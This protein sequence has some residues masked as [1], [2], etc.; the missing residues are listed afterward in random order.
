MLAEKICGMKD[1]LVAAIRESLRVPSVGG[2][3]AEGAPYGEGPRKALDWTLDFAAR[4]GFR[5]KNVDNVAG[6]AEM[7]TGDEMVA[8][9]GHLDVVPEGKGWTVDPWGGELKDGMIWGRGVLDNKGPVMVALFAAKALFDAGLKLKRRVRVIFG[10]NEERGS[11]CMKRY[12]ELG[13]ELPA[14]GFTPDADYPIIYAEKGIITYTLSMPFAPSGD[15]KVVSLEGG[16]AANVVMAEVK[17]VIEDPRPE[18]RGRILTA[19]KAWKGPQ[20][21]SLEASE[22]GD[23]VT[24]LMKG[25]PAHGSTPEKGVNAL[26]CLAGFMR[27]ARLKGEQ[28]EFFNAFNSTVAFETDG[29]S[30]AVAMKDSVSGSLTACVGVVKAA[31]GRVSFTVNLRYPVTAAEEDVTAPIE[32]TFKAAGMKVESASKTRPLYMPP[33]SRLIR[34]LQKVYTEET[35]QEATLLAIGGGT[36]AKTMPNVV[37]FGPVFPG[38][39]Y[40]I[41]EEDERWSV[42]DIM[43]NAHIMARALAE[44]AEE[45]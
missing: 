13:E 3:P 18:C 16:V 23:K 19:A 12:V 37:A 40:K 15:M 2:E 9:L 14:A 27:E 41:H 25:R 20:G 21:S 34:A 43:K 7:G 28:G 29:K 10:T 30:L 36:Y 35:G 1:E 38:Q 26:A 32:K 6:W 39:D 42:E 45:E 5:T 8:V 33:E 44:L 31:G 17:A 11:K 22:E 4:M 24:L